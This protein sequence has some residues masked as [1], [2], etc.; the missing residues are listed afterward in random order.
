M[1][2]QKPFD[3]DAYLASSPKQEFNPDKYLAGGEQPEPTPTYRGSVLPFTTYSDKSVRFEP[4]TSGLTGGLYQGYK[5]AN[6]YV[7]RVV[8]GEASSDVSD[9]RVMGEVFN[10]A[11][12][13]LGTNPFVRSGDRAIAGVKGVKQDLSLA[14]TPTVQELKD[15]GGKQISDVVDLPVKYNPQHIPILADQIEQNLLKEGVLPKDAP[16]IYETLRYMRQSTPPPGSTVHVEPANLI[17]LRKNIANKFGKAD[18][19]QKGV[20]VAFEHLNNFIEN[21]PAG[22]VLSG[23]AAEVGTRYATGRA[24]YAA[25][26]RGEELADISRTADLRA[27][28]AN[29]GQ[30]LDN[31]VRGRVATAVL[32]DARMRGFDPA[33]KAALEA[34][35]TGTPVRNFMRNWGNRLGGGGGLGQ[36]VTSGLAAAGANFLG[37][38]PAV[39]GAAAVIA[40]GVGAYLKN[41][42]AKGTVGALEAVQEATQRRSPLFLEKL[43]GQ[44]LVPSTPGRDAMARALLQMQLRRQQSQVP[45]YDPNLT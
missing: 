20:G 25:G 24:N 36:G 16:G 39:T 8:S 32:D 41:Q 40:P 5:Q 23:P 22:A 44:D 15:V 33:E 29:S 9:P 21:P 31:S 17:S 19:N 10:M 18:E 14:R 26:M 34:I 45:D 43:P 13:G 7:N 27:A 1:A 38:G 11:T 3:P 42:A 37:A 28:A 30:N 6:D 4:L 12:L 35:P 2:E